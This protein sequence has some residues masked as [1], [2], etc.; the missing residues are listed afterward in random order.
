MAFK[1]DLT[2]WAPKTVEITAATGEV[3]HFKEWMNVAMMARIGGL[4]DRER[5]LDKDVDDAPELIEELNADARQ[6]AWRIIQHDDEHHLLTVEQ[7][8]EWFP[9][10]AVMQFLGFLLGSYLGR[11]SRAQGSLQMTDTGEIPTPSTTSEPA[12]VATDTAISTGSA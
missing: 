1:L 9:D 3:V 8:R 12:D 2:P 10:G 7:V 6:L 11:M 5:S 4:I